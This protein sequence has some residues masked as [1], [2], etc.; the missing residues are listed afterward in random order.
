MTDASTALALCGYCAIEVLASGQYRGSAITVSDR[1]DGDP[2]LCGECHGVDATVVVR[3]V[4]TAEE[5]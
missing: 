1:T 4:A 5:G 2:V 3:V